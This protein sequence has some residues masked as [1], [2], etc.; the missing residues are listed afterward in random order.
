MQHFFLIISI[1]NISHY[2]FKKNFFHPLH[3]I[4][5]QFHLFNSRIVAS[6]SSCHLFSSPGS[7]DTMII[8][9]IHAS[10]KIL[11]KA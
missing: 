4:Q 11:N 3:N 2:K 10:L 7:N 5:N 1:A 6:L 9:N 8:S